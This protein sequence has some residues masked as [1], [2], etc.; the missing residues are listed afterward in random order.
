M[1]GVLTQRED[2]VCGSSAC[3]AQQVQMLWGS[4]SEADTSLADEQLHLASAFPILQQ[5][6]SGYGEARAGSSGLDAGL[7]ARLF[8]YRE[9][10]TSSQACVASLT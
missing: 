1:D 3:V 4:G 2:Q 10:G 5:A 8:G 7:Q 9:L 6:N